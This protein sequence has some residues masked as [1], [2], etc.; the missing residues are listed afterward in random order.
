MMVMEWLHLDL[1]LMVHLEM[2]MVT[3]VT[4]D[5]L[6]GGGVATS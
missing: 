6:S 5:P 4:K 1:Y 2:L 3:S